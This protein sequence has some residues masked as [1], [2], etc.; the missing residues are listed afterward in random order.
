MFNIFKKKNS[1]PTIPGALTI[2]DVPLEVQKAVSI[3][4][5]V[6]NKE[7]ED[8]SKR[9]SDIVLM[10]GREA[11]KTLD[12]SFNTY[13]VRLFRMFELLELK[14]SHFENMIDKEEQELSKL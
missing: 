2:E 7:L 12:S 3:M 4:V 5:N 13:E 9:Y 6:V 10:S 8:Q 14:M 1:V 11:V